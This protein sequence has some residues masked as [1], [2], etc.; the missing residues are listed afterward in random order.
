VV[1]SVIGDRAEIE[2][3]KIS[4]DTVA[5]IDVHRFWEA[6]QPRVADVERQ[7]GEITG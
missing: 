1:V 7:L 4:P 3:A 5:Q 2:L 6:L